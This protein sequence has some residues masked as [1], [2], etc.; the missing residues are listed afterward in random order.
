MRKKRIVVALGGNALGYTPEE[1][2]K[3]ATAAARAIAELRAEGHELIIGHGNGPQVGM[4]HQAVNDA[5]KSARIPFRMP[6]PECTA[7]SQ[8]YIGFHLQRVLREEMHR[9]GFCDPVVSLVTQ[10]RVDPSD[11]A[12]LHPEKPIGDFC[13]AEEAARMEKEKGWIYMEDAGRGYRRVVPS[14]APAEIM[15][16]EGIR[17][18]L[19]AGIV[20]ITVGGGGIPVIRTAEGLKGVD[21]VIDK[22]RASEKLAED[23]GADILMILTAVD[24]VYLSFGKPGQKALET[25]RAAEAERYLREGHFAPGSMLPKMEAAI[26][27]A[28]SAPD[29]CA[30]ITSLEKAC[31]ALHGNEGTRIVG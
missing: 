24:R 8:G 10:V 18:M 22:D 14:P 27:F 25:L 12:F 23:I 19:E 5:G 3:A 1:Q 13:T 21:A 6:F 15:E 26:R 17:R 31:A 28:A 16:L 7:M 9:R 30:V 2:E 20:V 4:I 11:P 29:R